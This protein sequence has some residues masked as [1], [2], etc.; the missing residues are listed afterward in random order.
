MDGE[1]ML[2][3]MNCSVLEEEIFVSCYVIMSV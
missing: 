3:V 2:E 1:R